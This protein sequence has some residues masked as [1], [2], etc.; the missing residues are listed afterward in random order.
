V[1]RP[2]P[3]PQCRADASP[4]RV[5]A[6]A[7]G[8]HPRGRGAAGSAA[9]GAGVP[10]ARLRT[11]R[12]TRARTSASTSF[13]MITAGS[14]LSRRDAAAGCGRGAH[15]ATTE[16]ANRARSAGRPLAGTHSRGPRTERARSGANAQTTA[17]PATHRAGCASG[18][19]PQHTAC[20]AREVRRRPGLRWGGG[21]HLHHHWHHGGH[22]CQGVTVPV[23]GGAGV[24][25]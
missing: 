5:V 23:C 3:A 12:L 21:L 20:A 1:R 17:V 8:P 13:S 18:T 4:A 6:S 11:G 24:T 7:P 25:R 2:A 9:G 19:S 16:R 10:R 15:R 22:V 14:V